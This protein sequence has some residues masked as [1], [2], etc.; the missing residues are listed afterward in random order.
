MADKK[1]HLILLLAALLG[2]ARASAE[3]ELRNYIAAIVND[4][5]ITYR[6]VEDLTMADMENLWNAYRRQPELFADKAKQKMTDGLE[7]L[8]EK[9]LI[10]DD[11][12]TSGF[13]IPENIIDDEVQSR[14]RQ[15]FADRVTLTKTL[16]ARGTTF[17]T[18]RRQIRDEFILSIMQNRNVS[19]AVLIS[20]QKIDTYYRTN[21]TRFQ[22]G[23]EVK[24]RVIVLNRPPAGGIDDAKRL[25]QEIL[26]KIQQ[27][28]SFA[29]MAGIH[30]EVQRA[31]NGLWG[32]RQRTGLKQGFADVAF[33]LNAGQQSGMIGHAKEPDETYWI[34]QYN[35]AGQITSARKY[36][37]KDEP[38]DEKKFDAPPAAG[39][40]PEPQE[41]YLMRIEERRVAR[42]RPLAEVR[43]EIERELIVQENQR[44]RKK[45]IDRLKAKSFVR[46]F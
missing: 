30:S 4:S 8:M 5:V 25:A 2:G 17:E 40:L 1:F 26:Q 13:R 15:R 12:K 31:E 9:Q 22:M 28:T 14:I 3:A 20:P 29:E 10:L 32:W 11:F 18:F 7:L 34:Y 36:T 38:L 37:A 6:E 23:D 46:Y 41:I 21:L 42:T 24:L 44:L 33:T 45:W 16:Q 27:G 19:S 35:P 39:L 43:E